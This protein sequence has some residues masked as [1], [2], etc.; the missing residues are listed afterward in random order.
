MTS[1]LLSLVPPSYI[2]ALIRD[3]GNKFFFSSTNMHSQQTFNLP[4]VFSSTNTE[5]DILSGKIPN[6]YD[7][8]WGRSVSLQP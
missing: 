6:N 1:S 4:T 3:F 2:V 8:V 5:M 7:K